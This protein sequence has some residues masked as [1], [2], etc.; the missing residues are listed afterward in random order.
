M[1]TKRPVVLSI[2][3]FDP[4]GGAGILA[5]IKTFEQHKV[6]GFGVL[7]ANTFQ[8]DTQV[9]DIDW[10]PGWK[11]QEQ[12]GVLMER[13]KIDWFKIGIVENSAVLQ[14]IISFVIAQNPDAK[15]IWDPV[16]KS[17][18]GFPFF[19]SQHNFASILQHITVLT[20]N[21]TEFKVLIGTEE[22]ALRLSLSTTIYLKGGHREGA[23]LGCDLL[24]WKGGKYIFP[25]KTIGTSKHGSGCVL[26]SAICSNL[27]LQLPVPQ[28]FEKAKSYIE[29]FLSSNPSL[30]GDHLTL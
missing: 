11:I 8:T 3:G 5:D 2:A 16:L 12:I 28:V 9:C 17:S 20:P 22:E 15:F 29:K 18:S 19:E 14:Q 7:T 6:C 26:A 4:T 24:F 21:L 25:P 13:W 30:L 23:G 1:E 27:A 10:V